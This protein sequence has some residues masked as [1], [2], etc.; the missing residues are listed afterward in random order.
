MH[1]P[2]TILI[3]RLSRL[4]QNDAHQSGLK[5]TQWEAL[6]FLSRANKYSR[7]PGGLT[8]YLSMT[9]GTVSQTLIALERKGLIQKQTASNDRRGV[10]IELTES[11]RE[12][13][14]DDPLQELDKVVRAF[15]KDT[16]SKLIGALEGLLKKMIEH[17]QGR[18]FD[19]CKT[20][21]HFQRRHKYGAPHYCNLLSEPLSVEESAQI[22][23]E[24]DALA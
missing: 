9:K 13:L 21:R 7:S 18:P 10:Q 2:I 23:I 20:C 3:E 19:A 4:V 22:C 8:A 14:D 24:Q 6:R 11:G 17:R 1:N 5:P 15:P 16:S 12:L